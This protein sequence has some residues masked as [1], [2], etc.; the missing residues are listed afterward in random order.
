M[1]YK[2]L[3]YDIY[4]KFLKSWQYKDMRTYI[5]II[6]CWQGE[7]LYNPYITD[8]LKELTGK[9][10]VEDSQ[11][12]RV[13][14]IEGFNIPV[15]VVKSDGGYNYASTDLAALRLVVFANILLY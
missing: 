11:G 8:M 15:I 2:D 12:A 13:I 4:I 5:Y 10:L 7:S 1:D 3:S 6:S 14:F 9:N